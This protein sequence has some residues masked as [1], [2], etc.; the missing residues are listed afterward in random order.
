MW[1]CSSEENQGGKMGGGFAEKVGRRPWNDGGDMSRVDSHDCPWS[2]CIFDY[3]FCI[4]APCP[5]P[6]VRRQNSPS[7][8][9]PLPLGCWYGT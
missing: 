2:S 6:Q 5:H 9:S 1:Q 7:Q 8:T 4:W 3:P